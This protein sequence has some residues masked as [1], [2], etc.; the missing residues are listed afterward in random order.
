MD[1]AELRAVFL[2]LLTE[3]GPT[4]DRRRRDYNQAIFAPPERGGYAIFTGTDL[5]MVL[6]VFD[7]AVKKV[8]RGQR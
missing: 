4:P 8:S 3:D 5:A 7:R 6:D 1:P 2:Q